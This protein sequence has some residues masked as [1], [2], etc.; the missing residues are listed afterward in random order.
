MNWLQQWFGT[1]AKPVQFTPS[2]ASIRLP[3][4][5]ETLQ[6]LGELDGMLLFDGREL[7]LDFQT[8][9]AL[10]GMIKMP[11]QSLL[12]PLAAIESVRAGRG[13]LWMMPYIEIELNDFRLLAK[14]PGASGGRWRLSVRMRDRQAL[15]RMA[16][17]IGFARAQWLH[18]RLAADLPPI[19]P[20]GVPMPELQNHAEAQRR[21]ELE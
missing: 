21:R 12:V 19:P 17:A 3:I 2:L 15:A 14:V 6:G 8:A 7:R 9:D 10:F 18:D 16:G 13:F 5:A 11:P 4:K 20:A 1:P